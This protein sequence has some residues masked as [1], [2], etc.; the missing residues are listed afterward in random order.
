MNFPLSTFCIKNIIVLHTMHKWT[1]R[2]MNSLIWTGEV[3]NVNGV[4]L[5]YLEDRQFMSNS[6]RDRYY[7]HLIAVTCYTSVTVAIELSQID[8]R[9]KQQLNVTKSALSKAY[10]KIQVTSTPHQHSN[11]TP[12]CAYTYTCKYN[13]IYYLF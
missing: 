7:I 2:K 4:V 9:R 10:T 5:P 6:H 3:G 11:E 12:D 8:T 13:V 1:M